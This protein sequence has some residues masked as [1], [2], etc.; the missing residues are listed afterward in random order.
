MTDAM[1]ER[2]RVP[3]VVV[4]L[5][6]NEER[7]IA[8]CL[9]GAAAIG[10]PLVV[11]DSAST[12]NTAVLAVDAGAEV[13]AFEWN[14]HYPK[15]KQW[16]LEYVQERFDATWVLLLDA[17][18]RVTDALACFVRSV[19]RSDVEDQPVAYRFRIEYRFAGG[20]NTHGFE[21]RKVALLRPDRVRFAP[22]DD[23]DLPHSWEVEGHYQPDA[24][25]EIALAPV[26]LLHDD[27]DHLDD[28]IARHNR[29]S[30]WSAHLRFREHRRA[31]LGS[32]PEWPARVFART[33]F[34]GLV[35]FLHSYVVRRGFLDGTAGFDFAVARGFYYWLSSAKLRELR[36]RDRLR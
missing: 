13:V 14:G 22:R 11:V 5:T 31:A 19:V 8:A 33:P 18:E 4:V 17:D 7:N 10:A 6:K 27:E 9:E 36:R 24:D 21:A 35:A 26:V 1:D 23:L 29:Y 20:H 32:P 25:G 15:K 12:D 34:K 16:S 28:W 3:V 2:N 30:D